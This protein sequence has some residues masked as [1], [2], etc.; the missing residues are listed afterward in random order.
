MDRVSCRQSEPRLRAQ[1]VEGV[2]AV[3]RLEN[4]GVASSVA[5]RRCQPGGPWRRLLPGVVLLGS[6]PPTWRQKL[7][8]A[9]VY[10]VPGAQL[11][12]GAAGELHGLRRAQAEGLVQLLVPHSTRRRSV[13]FV[14]VER[15]HRLPEPA[16]LQGLPCAPVVRAVLDR[17]R[18]MGSV[19]AV[20][21]LLAEAVQRQLCTVHALLDELAAGTTRGS[22]LVRRQLDELEGGARSVAEFRAKKLVRRSGLPEPQWNVRLFD[23]G[24][25]L[26]G[27]PDAWWAEVGLAWEIDSLEFHL[28]PPDYARTLRRDARYAA[29]GIAVL[30]TLPSR[31][32]TEPRAVLAELRECYA[33][34]ARRPAPEFLVRPA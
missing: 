16:V 30:P 21:A 14:V 3:A 22:A 7:I 20:Q 31:L 18:R 1:A 28:S 17:A 9:L 13:G 19:E 11:T 2:I 26:V 32:V 12:G 10:A 29:C 25:T 6:G 15:T 8:A 23:A 4:L 27:Q 34:A 33:T 24:G 5:Y